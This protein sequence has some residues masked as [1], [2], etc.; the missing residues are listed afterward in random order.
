M[1]GPFF[2]VGGKSYYLSPVSIILILLAL[3]ISCFKVVVRFREVYLMAIARREPL[4]FYMKLEDYNEQ[5][6]DYGC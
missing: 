2:S 6:L 4:L 1:A 5:T 3:L